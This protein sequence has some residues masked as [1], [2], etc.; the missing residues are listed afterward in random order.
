MGLKMQKIHE[1]PGVLASR[2]PKPTM[3]S[4]DTGALAG[5]DLTNS[6]GE[7]AAQ[8]RGSVWN[9]QSCENSM[10]PD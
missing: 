1:L 6:G 4:A 3:L 8:A 2:M 9:T 7:C 10:F 5:N